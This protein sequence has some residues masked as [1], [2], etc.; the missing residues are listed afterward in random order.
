MKSH[1]HY[2]FFSHIILKSLTNLII[3]GSPTEEHS[4]FDVLGWPM[5]S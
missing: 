5:I 2:S 4:L 3:E 1:S